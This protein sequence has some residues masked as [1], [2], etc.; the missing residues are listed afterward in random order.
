MAYFVKHAP[1]NA[2]PLFEGTFQQV[3]KWCLKAQKQ[4][5]LKYQH[6]EIY[7]AELKADAPEFVCDFFADDVGEY[8]T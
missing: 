1:P 5:L 8:L 4:N 6:Y 3:V 2:T 7:G